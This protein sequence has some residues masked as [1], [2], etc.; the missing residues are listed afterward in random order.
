MKNIV[1]GTFILCIPLV[2]WGWAYEVSYFSILGL[3]VNK[4]LGLLHYIYSSLIFLAIIFIVVIVYTAI[5]KFFSNNVERNDWAGVKEALGKT[6]LTK[7]ISDARFAFLFSL[8]ALLIVIFSPEVKFLDGLGR[9]LGDGFMLL[10]LFN[11]LLFFASLYLS[12]SHS[13]FAIIS[14]FVLSI[15]TCFSMGGISHARMAIEIKESVI[16]D[17]SLVVITR[18]NG[19]YVATAKPV[20][21]PLPNSLK[22]YLDFLNL[23]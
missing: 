22:K 17:D 12:P 9:L 13:K 7:E 8:G 16:R 3:N 10:V 2:L 5:T 4:T 15:G 6:E 14:V 11:I 19:E 20:K 23:D 18:E 1:L 21:I